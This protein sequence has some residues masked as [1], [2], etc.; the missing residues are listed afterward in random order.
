MRNNTEFGTFVPGVFGFF[1]ALTDA[2]STD[3]NNSTTRKTLEGASVPMLKSGVMSTD[4]KETDNTFDYSI[5]LPGYSKD[6]I[7]IDIEDGV[8]TVKAEVNKEENEENKG[9]I[10]RERFTSSCVRKFTVDEMT[11]ADDIKAS[12]TNGVLSISVAKKEVVKPEKKTI[13]IE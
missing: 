3:F 13:V 7:S 10:K 12:F 5:S 11:T 6:D 9:Y 2:M 8:M 1:D 4:I